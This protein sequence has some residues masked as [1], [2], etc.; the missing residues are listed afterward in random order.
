MADRLKTTNKKSEREKSMFKSINRRLSIPAI[1]GLL[2]AALVAAEI[3]E[4]IEIE[5]EGIQLIGQ[6]ET[7]ARDIHGNAGRLDS[8]TRTG[9]VS[10][11]S[12]NEHLMQI[13]SLVND[14]LRPTLDRLTEIQESMPE[15]QQD[16]VNQLLNSAIGLASNTNSAIL[17]MNDGNLP[18]LLNAEYGEY[19]TQLN[20]HAEALVKIADAAG[21]YADAH[22]NAADAGL[23]VAKY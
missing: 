14:E 3:K 12:H 1:F 23:K 5:R 20:E 2:P 18:V 16:A 7:V 11:W 8:F 19:V 15:W 13:K 9:Q 21:S 4:P 22:R 17:S 6:M 10:T